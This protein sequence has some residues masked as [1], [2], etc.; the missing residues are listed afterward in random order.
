V[1]YQVVERGILAIYSAVRLYHYL[2]PKYDRF[3]RPEPSRFVSNT[4]DLDV[5]HRIIFLRVRRS[6][7]RIM[8]SV[9]EIGAEGYDVKVV[10]GYDFNSAANSYFCCI[11]ASWS[12]K[13]LP[14][15]WLLGRKSTAFW[16]ICSA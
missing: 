16:F 6:W 9:W 3:G 4:I 2:T 7:S 8:T 10:S 14:T 1:L 5:R 13:S 11:H 15:P 12:T